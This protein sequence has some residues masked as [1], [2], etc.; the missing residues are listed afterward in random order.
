MTF[1]PLDPNALRDLSSITSLAV[2]ISRIREMRDLRSATDRSVDSLLVDHPLLVSGEI[3]DPAMDG[4]RP[5]LLKHVR[6]P[7]VL[8]PHL[9]LSAPMGV[10]GLM[11]DGSI[12]RGLGFA[13]RAELPNFSGLGADLEAMRARGAM[14]YGANLRDA[15]LARAALD[16]ADL[17]HARLTGADLSGADLDHA[18]LRGADLSFA[19]LSR[20]S[21]DGVRWEGAT[22]TGATFSFDDDDKLDVLAMLRCSWTTYGLDR[23]TRRDAQRFDASCYGDPTA[24]DRWKEH[25]R[26]PY[27]GEEATVRPLHFGEDS[28]AWNGGEGETIGAQARRQT[29]ADPVELPIGTPNP[30]VLLLR[31]FA[32][33]GVHLSIRGEDVNVAEDGGVARA[34]ALLAPSPIRRF[35]V[36]LT[37]T[38]NVT[39]QRRDSATVYVDAEDEDAA[40]EMVEE[41]PEDYVCDW[42]Y[43][44]TEEDGDEDVD[45]IT[46]DDVEPD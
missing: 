34:L 20:A 42:C 29:T 14:L 46:V 8:L 6:L 4:W 27:G 3:V 22:I 40:R 21:L 33:A 26:C 15:R 45:E 7:G 23:N 24:F 38:V 2:L 36:E 28:C 11:L 44:D 25:G 9:D 37:R 13:P 17:R 39:A 1:T 31:L 16:N 5:L 41:S 35:R 12:A 43:G 10:D 30:T 32:H 19:D 18:N